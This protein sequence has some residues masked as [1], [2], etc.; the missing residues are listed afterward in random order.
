VLPL[1]RTRVSVRELSV[2]IPLHPFV[3]EGVLR[4]PAPVRGV[5]LFTQGGG[6]RRL[7][8]RE[9][10]VVPAL[11]E[12]GLGTCHIDLLTADEERVVDEGSVRSRL[13]LDLLAG[14]VVI[15][16]DWLRANPECAGLPLGY[17]GAGSG[18]VAGLV[19]ASERS[20]D[21]RAIVCRDAH[22]EVAGPALVS[23][24]VPTL[25][26]V[27]RPARSLLDSNRRALEVLPSGEKRLEIVVPATGGLDRQRRE[28]RLARL[29]IDWFAR[30]LTPPPR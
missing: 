24:T 23:V 6:K 26:I 11:N 15:A 8:R 3:L 21:V 4:L 28:E 16:T 2:R 12:A 22:A 30:F 9:D 13:D 27:A 19:A 5:V 7:R 17:C 14:R 1:L 18:A 25:L 20:G 10:V 29:S